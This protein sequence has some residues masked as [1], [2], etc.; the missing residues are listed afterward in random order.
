MLLPKNPNAHTHTHTLRSMRS[1]ASFSHVHHIH[2]LAAD[3]TTFNSAPDSLILG[4]HGLVR[5]I[6]LNDRMHALTVDT[7]GDV[8]VWDVIRGVCVGRFAKEEV[9]DAASRCGSAYGDGSGRGSMGGGEEKSHSRERSPREALE[10]VRERIEGEAVVAPWSSVDTKTGVLTVHVNERSCFEAEI[11][12]DEA[13]FTQ[14]RHF[15]DEF[16]LLLRDAMGY[17]NTNTFAVNIGK[18]VLRNLFLGFI[19]EEQR[20]R[21]KQDGHGH[22]NNSNHSQ[23]TLHRG[24]APTHIDLSNSNS[25][26]LKYLFV[27]VTAAPRKKCR[28]DRNGLQC[29]GSVQRP[30]V[31]VFC[32]QMWGIDG[33]NAAVK[34]CRRKA[35]RTESFQRNAAV[36][37]DK[38]PVFIVPQSFS[39]YTL[40]YITLMKSYWVL[41]H[42]QVPQDPRLQVPQGPRLQVPQ[43]LHPASSAIPENSG[44]M[45]K[46][47]T[48]YQ[49][50]FRPKLPDIIIQPA[51]EQKSGKKRG[52]GKGGI[53]KVKAHKTTTVG[54]ETDYLRRLARLT[55]R[56]LTSGV[57]LVGD[58]FSQGVLAT[59]TGWQGKGLVSKGGMQQ[60]IASGEV[61]ESLSKFQK[62]PYNGAPL[63]VFD[64]TERLLIIRLSKANFHDEII[65]SLLVEI[66]RLVQGSIENETTRLKFRKQVRGEH[67]ACLLGIYRQSMQVPQMTEW[68]Q[69]HLNEAETFISSSVHKRLTFSECV[70]FHKRVYQ[71]EAQFGVFFNFCIN[72]PF[73]DG[74]S[75]VHL[76]PHADRKNIAGGYCALY[77]YEGNKS[78]RHEEKAWLVIWEAGLIL[79]LPPGVLLFY[80]SALFYHF[81]IDIGGTD[82]FLLTKNAFINWDHKDIQ[83]VLTGDGCKPDI[84]KGNSYPLNNDGAEGRASLVWFNQASML[85]TS[86]TGYGTLLEAK[87]AGR[88]TK[89]DFLDDSL[90][91][92]TVPVPSDLQPY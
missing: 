78:F 16:R 2:E 34:H 1:D 63:F 68:H 88:N 72:V 20:M 6:M 35:A 45:R 32:L 21:R 66:Q 67:F 40:S 15:S 43:G 46:N 71:K 83:F 29:P 18:W 7:S 25:S 22:S 65:G 76:Y 74:L 48:W 17:T 13:G 10:A 54:K 47:I 31:F 52:K 28:T 82:G 90:K 26:I 33:P 38:K 19:R 69:N 53:E 50:G 59:S 5:A 86:E 56:G 84:S 80:P 81:N 8:A 92:F 39:T 89:T 36:F 49:G 42:L 14:D 44:F 3:A 51:K 37:S 64:E 55:R 12:G 77:V 79:E 27:L 41:H 73:R 11:Y 60:H 24:T 87:K 70:E 57:R 4:S 91:S 85:Q 62:V 9:R 23:S 30:S 61:W 75:R 58:G